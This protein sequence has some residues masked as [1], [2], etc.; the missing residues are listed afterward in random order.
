MIA[1]AQ[2]RRGT[3]WIDPTDD[4][5]DEYLGAYHATSVTACPMIQLPDPHEQ[6]TLT[7]KLARVPA[8]LG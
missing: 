1:G 4:D 6:K 2:H 5:N 3:E 8:G 7:S